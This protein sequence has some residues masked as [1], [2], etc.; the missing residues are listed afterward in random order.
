[1]KKI[2]TTLP[3]LM[4]VATLLIACS[5]ELGESVDSCVY[6]EILANYIEDKGIRSAFITAWSEHGRAFDRFAVL[7]LDY[8]SI[9]AIIINNDTSY[10]FL[11]L[12]YYHGI[13]YDSQQFMDLHHIE[14]NGI[15]FSL[16]GYINE[17]LGVRIRG[18]QI[19]KITINQGILDIIR[20]AHSSD[21]DFH[22]Q[23]N[24]T[25]GNGY[26]HF[27]TYFIGDTHV[28]SEEFNAFASM[29]RN[30]SVTWHKFVGAEHS[31]EEYSYILNT[32]KNPYLNNDIFIY[33][34]LHGRLFEIFFGEYT[35]LEQ[36]AVRIRAN[37]S[38]E[39]IPD[40]SGTTIY[41]SSERVLV[42]GVTISEMPWYGVS[43]SEINRSMHSGFV[44]GSPLIDMQFDLFVSV[45]MR[46]NP[47]IHITNLDTSIR[48][49]FQFYIYNSYTI[50]LIYNN[51]LYRA[52]RI[53]TQWCI[54]ELG[55]RIVAANEIW[56][57]WWLLR[58]RFSRENQDF[59]TIISYPA[60]GV[61]LLPESGFKSLSEVRNY[62]LKYYTESWVDC[63]LS[64][65]FPRSCTK[66]SECVIII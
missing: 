56:E 12:Y 8:D 46:N 40:I 18:E 17:E 27:F 2:F 42:D 43:I 35:V 52:E 50:Y 61:R 34:I 49:D 14:K 62:L 65:E 38:D 5:G 7:H 24:E 15:V 66:Q 32:Y 30:N 26:P 36:I 16:T 1:M 60:H 41:M 44:P 64:R 22:V 39:V 4:L 53:A 54:E 6:N 21:Y 13:V 48:G 20:L 31:D 19:S 9:P 25:K 58:G 47:F 59:G 29:K 28:T 23:D 33:Q 51:A 63:Q 57:D 55:E 3:L 10:D 45:E 37:G 11:I